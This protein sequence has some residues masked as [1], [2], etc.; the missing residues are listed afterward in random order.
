MDTIIHKSLV[1]IEMQL[2]M[3]STFKKDQGDVEG[4]D[5]DVWNCSLDKV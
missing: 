2:N 3:K 4:E 5:E 1:I